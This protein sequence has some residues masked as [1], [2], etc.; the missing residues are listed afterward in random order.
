MISLAFAAGLTYAALHLPITRV[1]QVRVTGTE[2]LDT[3]AVAEI[4]RLAG[5]SMFRLDLHGARR[6]LLEVPQVKDVRFS[7]DWPNTVTVRVVERVPWGYWS[8]GGRD[9]PVDYEGVVLAAG[10]PSAASTRIVE[11]GASRIMGPGDRV[12]PDAIALADRIFRESPSVLGRGVKELE[13]KAGVGITAVFTNG[14]RV[15]FGDDRAYDYKF[16]VLSRLLEQL[17][18]AGRTPS[19]IDLRF[20]E[21][22]T[23]Q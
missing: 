16:A 2:T 23:Y 9:Y 5:Q 15:T 6:R 20:G 3:A 10:A 22:V 8:V 12:D 21:R 11:T 7:R 1:Q 18:A 13:Y 17:G 4:T 14:L 19:A